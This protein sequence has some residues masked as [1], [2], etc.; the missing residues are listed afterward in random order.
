MESDSSPWAARFQPSHTI[1]SPG[2]VGP[3]TRS[4]CLRVWLKGW[5]WASHSE[6]LTWWLWWAIRT[7]NPAEVADSS[8]FPGASLNARGSCHG[9][10]DGICFLYFLEEFIYFLMWATFKK[11]LL[12]LL[13]CCFSFRH[14]GSWFPSQG[15]KPHPVHWKSRVLTTGPL[16]KSP[17]LSF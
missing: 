16:G 14:V 13:P 17:L 11:S 9:G 3:E 10:A 1:D 2:E 15:W 7:E 8:P 6:K 4:F 5:S 12:D